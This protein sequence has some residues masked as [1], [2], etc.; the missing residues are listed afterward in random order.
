MNCESTGSKMKSKMMNRPGFFHFFTAETSLPQMLI[1]MPF[2]KCIG[3]VLP[4]RVFLRD[5]SYNLWCV[6][7]GKVGEDWYFQNGWRRFVR[8]NALKSCDFIVFDYFE[9]D[10]FDFKVLG[11][12]QCE[13]V[14]SGGLVYYDTDGTDEDL[15]DLDD[16]TDYEV[17]EDDEEE[18]D[19]GGDDDDHCCEDE[20]NLSMKQKI[21]SKGD[22]EKRIDDRSFVKKEHKSEPDDDARGGMYKVRVKKEPKRERD[23]PK[24][25]R[26]DGCEVCVKKKIKHKRDDGCD[27]Q[28]LDD[29]ADAVE[30]RD[31]DYDVCVKKEPQ[32]EEDDGCDAGLADHA[33]NHGNNYDVRVKKEPQ[34]EGDDGCDK[35]LDDYSTDVRDDTENHENVNIRRSP[36][37]LGDANTEKDDNAFIDKEPPSEADANAD[38]DADADADD[39]ADDDEEEEIEDAGH[40]PSEENEHEQYAP[41]QANKAEKPGGPTRKRASVFPRYYGMHIFESGLVPK[42][43]NPYFITHVAPRRKGDLFIP[44]EL[45]KDH[46][47]ELPKPEMMLVDQQGRTFRGKYKKWKDGRILYSKGW[48]TLWKVNGVSLD[49]FCLCEFKRGENYGLYLKVT[50]I[51]VNGGP[52]IC[53]ADD[54]DQV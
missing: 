16:A 38:P 44:T 39:D 13:T 24:R 6:K 35:V 50:I 25:E 53:M 37:I 23:E 42:P 36:Q 11:T 21:S 1:P 8:D 20:Y 19:F 51:Y 30:N 9:K 18:W 43:R 5:R 34:H 17:E 26:D 41:N 32:H 12:D 7:V 15:D 45:I 48:R 49:D 2:I 54:S 10:M 47:L 27:D 46:H 4:K 31:N 3:R 29:Y 40:T 33:Q 52:P 22:D 14:G 28:D